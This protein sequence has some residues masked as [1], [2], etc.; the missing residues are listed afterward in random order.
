MRIEIHSKDFNDLTND[1][2]V[3]HI[4]T[5]TATINHKKTIKKVGK[6]T[7]SNNCSLVA[8]TKKNKN[9]NMHNRGGSSFFIHSNGSFA[10]YKSTQ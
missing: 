1:Q 3:T 6:R 5:V 8:Q 10:V 9:H 7:W 2:V 4:L